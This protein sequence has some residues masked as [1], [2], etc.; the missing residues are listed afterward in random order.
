MAAAEVDIQRQSITTY[1]DYSLEQKAEVLALFDA[2]EGNL[3]RTASET[4]IDPATLR[5][6]IRNRDKYKQIQPQK[7]IDLATKSELNAH[8][9]A[10]S[11]ANHDLENATL[12]S[13]ATAYGIMIDKM[14]LLR[15]LPTSITESVERQE[16]TVIL[17]SA[18][19][20][21]ID[22]TPTPDDSTT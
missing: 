3:K 6:W 7:I 15:G 10:D 16:L 9:L 17:E 22:V 5:Y 19:A 4:G 20:A 14:Q 13:K 11:I 1:R 2:N 8:L 21:A 18:L 12:A